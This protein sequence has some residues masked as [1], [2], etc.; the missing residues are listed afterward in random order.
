[1]LSFKKFT[2]L[3]ANKVKMINIRNP[4]KFCDDMSNRYRG[5]AIFRSSRRWLS[6]MLDFKKFDIL[7]ASRVKKV[8]VQH[9]T[10]FYVDRSNRCQDIAIS[11]F[12]DSGC[13]PSW[14]LK[15]SNF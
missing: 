14:F 7:T 2:M 1:M 3:T 8:T 15:R 5:I 4:A 12:E 6:A 10:K 13:P 9:R 11:S